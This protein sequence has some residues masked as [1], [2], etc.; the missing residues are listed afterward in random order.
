MKRMWLWLLALLMLFP[1][2]AQAASMMDVAYWEAQAGSLGDSEVA[3][4]AEISAMNAA[5][6]MKDDLSV[7]LSAYPTEVSG[8]TVLGYIKETAP[9][10]EGLS[11]SDAKGN[12][13]LTT[14]TDKEKLLS[15]QR[16]K[17]QNSS[18]RYAV[19]TT[20]TNL[21]LLPTLHAWFDADSVRRE[22]RLQGTAVDPAEPVV[23]LAESTDGDW[24][25]VQMRNYRGWAMKSA[26][27]FA[28]H[29]E[30]MNYAAPD[31]FLVV[32][33]NL[34]T[35]SVNDKDKEIF[36][37]GSRLPML[38]HGWQSWKVRMPRADEEGNLQEVTLASPHDVKMFREGYLPYTTNNIVRQ[39]F[40]FMGDVYGWG[41]L[42]NSVD[43]SALAADVYRT[44]GIELPRDSE[45]QEAAMLHRIELPAMLT[46]TERMPVIATAMPGSLLFQP[47]QV[48]ILLGTTTEGKPMVLQALYSYGANGLDGKEVQYPCR[49]LLSSLS[50]L[51]P[52]GRTFCKRVTSIGTLIPE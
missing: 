6:R 49:V 44:V 3:G 32:M 33:A 43:S 17:G 10:I 30:W 20:R 4:R 23:V 41:G 35:V 40:R 5:I 13:R 27:A 50:L 19:T 25:F 24:C 45:R 29:E 12:V 22:D 14:E 42:D 34:A 31:R 46:D 8:E 37:M 18:V 28:E 26:L 39:A 9:S 2:G 36:Q 52:D 16:E 21:R 11:L 38:G 1:A 15:V 47:G 7:D 48:S 51:G